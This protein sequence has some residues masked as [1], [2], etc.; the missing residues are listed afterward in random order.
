MIPVIIYNLAH[1]KLIFIGAFHLAIPVKYSCCS[2]CLMV[3]FSCMNA[4]VLDIREP[5]PIQPEG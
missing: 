4:V 1:I 3:P 2:A 5:S